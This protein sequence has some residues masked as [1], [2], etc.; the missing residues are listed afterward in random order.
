MEWFEAE[1][2]DP[3]ALEQAMQGVTTVFHAAGKVSFEARD[4]DRLFEVNAMGTTH[5]VNAALAAGVENLIHISSVAAIKRSGGSS[6]ESPIRESVEWTA[7]GGSGASTYGKSKRAGELEAWR[8]A[9]EGLN[10]FA[11]CPSIVIGAGNFRVSSGE[12]WSRVAAGMNWAPPGASGF[13][14]AT[15]IALAA[16]NLLDAALAGRPGIWGERFILSEGTHTFDEVLG[17]IA[18]QLGLEPPSKMPPVWLLTLAWR[19]L[20]LWSRL[21]G[22][23]ALLTRDMMQTATTTVYYSTEKLTSVLPE[24]KFKPLEEALA[25]T[26]P[27]FSR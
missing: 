7:D 22:T 13:V 17:G 20:E 10:V 27:L 11:L 12:M 5:V 16:G 1:L 23:R 25:E 8:G 21:T 6:L 24:F 26:A 18:L 14:A 4:A 9:A 19:P 2:G 15:D 3:H